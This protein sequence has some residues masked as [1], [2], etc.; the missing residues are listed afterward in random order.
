MNRTLPV[1][2]VALAA[3]SSPGTTGEPT[4]S[5]QVTVISAGAELPA[6]YKVVI[7]NG[8]PTAVAANRTESIPNVRTGSREVL[9]KGIPTNCTSDWYAPQSIVVPADAPATVTYHV[10]CAVPVTGRLVYTL[11]Q[12]A[13]I[14][15]D[16]YTM[17]ANGSDIRRLTTGHAASN[18]VVAPGGTRVAFVEGNRIW[19]MNMDGTNLHVLT[20]GPGV[21]KQPAWS[22][23]ATRLAFVRNDPI[24]SP[25]KL[26]VVTADGRLTTLVPAGSGLAIGTPAWSPDTN[27]IAF[28][29]DQQ[30]QVIDL[31]TAIYKNVRAPNNAGA[32]GNPMWAPAGNQIYYLTRLQGD[33]TGI[34]IVGS[35]GGGD[36]IF[37][38]TSQYLDAAV[39]NPQG[40]SIA[41]LGVVTG[42][43]I[44]VYKLTL[45]NNLLSNLT[46]VTWPTMARDPSWTP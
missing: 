37:F 40:N 39:L 6:T 25:G 10:D 1:M 24:G 23:D 43:A 26:M 8:A 44:D 38:R 18:P 20:G 34:G 4:S 33:S 29:R 27:H 16:L 36:T 30:I 19:L 2:L 22:P 7:D 32:A 14:S 21:D 5:I 15:A 31:T 11:S 17:M 3:C 13:G 46:S 35:D 9:L 28:V 12:N 42:G 41:F 45:T